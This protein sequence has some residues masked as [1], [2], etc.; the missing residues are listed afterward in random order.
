MSDKVEIP[1]SELESALLAYLEEE[2]GEGQRMTDI[3]AGF[4]GGNRG[5]EPAD[6]KAAIWRLLA[7]RYLTM[8]AERQIRRL[9]PDESAPEHG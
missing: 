8:N 9:Y 1:F 3:L 6:V 2:S 7:D 5:F 4:C